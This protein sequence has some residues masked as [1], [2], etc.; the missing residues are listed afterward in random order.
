MIVGR[1]VHSFIKPVSSSM[2]S[3][4]DTVV[5]S[6]SIPVL[7][8]KKKMNTNHLSSLKEVKDGVTG[9]C[10]LKVGKN[11]CYLG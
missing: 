9:I 10:Y 7:Q 1:C 11:R 5:I 2:L 3:T 8:H 4:Q 6:Q